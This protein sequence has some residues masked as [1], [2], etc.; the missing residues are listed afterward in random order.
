MQDGSAETLFIRFKAYAGCRFQGVG[1]WKNHI[2]MSRGCAGHLP[3]GGNR[4]V[5]GLGGPALKR[6]STPQL[7]NTHNMAAVTHRGRRLLEAHTTGD[8]TPARW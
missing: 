3:A 7:H 4:G 8:C 1:P 6:R 2:A 5:V